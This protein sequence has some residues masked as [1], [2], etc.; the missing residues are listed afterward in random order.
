MALR[1]PTKPTPKKRRDWRPKFLACLSLSPN[2]TGAAKAAHVNRQRVYEVRGE[3][4]KFAAAWDDAINQALDAAEGELYRRGVEGIN[5]PVTV[6]GQREV[7]R[8]YSD[9]LLI[10]LLKSHRPEKYRETIRHDVTWRE[11]V[12]KLGFDPDQLVN[13]FVAAMDAG[14]DSSGVSGEIPEQD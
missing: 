5:K 6:A 1:K 14:R 10:F 3:E 11:E 13:E 2:V 12:K 8:E 9:T 4:P 7:I